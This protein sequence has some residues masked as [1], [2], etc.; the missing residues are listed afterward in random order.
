MM[1]PAPHC[2]LLAAVGRWLLA[3]GRSGLMAKKQNEHIEN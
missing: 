2:S 1:S 3:G